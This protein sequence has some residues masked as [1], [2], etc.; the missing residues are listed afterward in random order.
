[1]LDPLRNYDELLRHAAEG[2][3]EGQNIPN[4]AVVAADA[5]GN[6]QSYMIPLNYRMP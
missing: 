2:P 5:K 4:A 6:E 1:M 3:D